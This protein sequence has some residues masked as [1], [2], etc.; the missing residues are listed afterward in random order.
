MYESMIRHA[1]APSGAP[2]GQNNVFDEQARRRIA[3]RI[4][5]MYA[6]R[7]QR[8][9]W[10]ASQRNPLTQWCETPDGRVAIVFPDK[11]GPGWSWCLKREGERTLFS[12]QRCL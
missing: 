11:S 3:A 8:I 2:E 10:R 4:T 6:A 12:G 5:A 1:Q 9:C 7:W